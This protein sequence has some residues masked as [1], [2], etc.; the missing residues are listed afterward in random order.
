MLTGDKGD[1]ARMIGISCG[2]LSQPNDKSER[3]PTLIKLESENSSLDDIKKLGTDHNLFE[4]MI[5]GLALSN[6]LSQPDY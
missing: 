6:L 3:S 5:S 4:L 2:L 1:T